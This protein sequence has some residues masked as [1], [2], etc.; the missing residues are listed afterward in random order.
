MAG[1]VG[2]EQELTS[3][4]TSRSTHSPPLSGERQQ[5]ASVLLAIRFFFF[6]ILARRKKIKPDWILAVRE[7]INK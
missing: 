7:I 4:T 5:S 2:S 6:E 1:H 3:V